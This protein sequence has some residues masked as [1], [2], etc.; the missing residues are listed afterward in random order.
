MSVTLVLSDM[1]VMFL[2]SF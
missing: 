2:R 1:L